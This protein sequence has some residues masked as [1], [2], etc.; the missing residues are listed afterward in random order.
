MYSQ[1]E[2][3]QTTYEGK[4]E[5]QIW[6]CSCVAAVREVVSL[7][8]HSWPIFPQCHSLNDWKKY[9]SIASLWFFCLNDL[10]LYLKIL[11]FSNSCTSYPKPESWLK[12]VKNLLTQLSRRWS[13]ASHWSRLAGGPVVCCAPH[14][15]TP[16]AAP[17]PSGVLAT[18]GGKRQIGYRNTGVRGEQSD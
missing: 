8:K 14:G 9:S 4:I 6:A 15:V 7:R 16:S 12:K 11:F 2:R 1:F 13:F 17:E 18:E 3:L 10:I 5:F